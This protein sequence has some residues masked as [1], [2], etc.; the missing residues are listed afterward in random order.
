[1]ARSSTPTTWAPHR[2]SPG[3]RKTRKT[4]RR[5]ADMAQKRVTLVTAT[6]VIGVLFLQLVTFRV[7]ET[8][9]AVVKT[10]GSAAAEDVTQPGLYWKWPWPIQEVVRQDARLRVLEGPLE[11]SVTE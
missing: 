3:P 10:F 1:S 8:E 11:E 4:R 2:V 5:D 6:L 9:R 7:R